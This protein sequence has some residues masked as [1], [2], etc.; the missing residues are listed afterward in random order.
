VVWGG[1]RAAGG[2]CRRWAGGRKDPGGRKKLRNGGIGR[3]KSDYFSGP[4]RRFLYADQVG[5]DRAPHTPHGCGS[6]Q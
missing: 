4:S 5:A 3:K 6:A 2:A 1:G